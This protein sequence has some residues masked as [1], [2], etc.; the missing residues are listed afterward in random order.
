M[1]RHHHLR[2][3]RKY[4]LFALLSVV[5]T[6]VGCQWI[7]SE[8]N[9]GKGNEASSVY[10]DPSFD[11]PASNQRSSSSIKPGGLSKEARDIEQRLGIY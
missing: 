7:K 6:Q 4:I 8:L 10:D 5:A 11:L 9:A 3:G 1:I 2:A